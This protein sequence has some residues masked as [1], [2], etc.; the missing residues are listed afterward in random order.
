MERIAIRSIKLAPMKISRRRFV[1]RLT[2][3]TAT[4][5]VAGKLWQRNLL[6]FCELP[7]GEEGAVFKVWLGD[8]PALQPDYGSVRL[9]I[10]PLGPSYPAGLFHPFLINRDAPVDTGLLVNNAGRPGKSTEP[11]RAWAARNHPSRPHESNWFLRRQFG[12]V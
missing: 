4:S 9:G 1:K 10:D 12:P 11:V 6:A 5:M 3:G 8:F 2:P 7:P